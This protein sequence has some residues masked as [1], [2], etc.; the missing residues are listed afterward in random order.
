MESEPS[1]SSSSSEMWPPAAGPVAIPRQA[2][3]HIVR[4]WGAVTAG[5][6]AVAAGNAR[7]TKVRIALYISY[8]GWPSVDTCVA[9]R[10]KRKP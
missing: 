3:M 9:V 10:R 4:T 6:R 7:L 1:L 2:F 8:G 5:W